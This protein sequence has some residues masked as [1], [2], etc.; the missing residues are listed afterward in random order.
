MFITAYRPRKR[1]GRELLGINLV[2]GNAL[3]AGKIRMATQW[4]WLCLLYVV[5]NGCVRGSW[6]IT[7]NSREGHGRNR[8]CP[9]CRCYNRI[10]WSRKRR[11]P[12]VRISV[13][14]ADTWSWDLP[15][16]K[17]DC[18]SFYRDVHSGTK[19]GIQALWMVLTTTQFT[20]MFVLLE[21]LSVIYD[22]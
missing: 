5:F 7:S 18:C 20:L 12:S 6:N 2:C 19:F 8:S 14:W 22:S 16:N 15:N 10:S 11:Q 17:Q 4:T 9:Y 21:C 13:L 3:C 1:R